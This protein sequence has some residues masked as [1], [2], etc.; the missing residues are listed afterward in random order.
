MPEDPEYEVTVRT[1]DLKSAD[2][3]MRVV[4]QATQVEAAD[5]RQVEVEEV[6]APREQRREE[7][8]RRVFGGLQ[9]P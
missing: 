3:V 4:E 6:K 7:F 9:K 1:G 2:Y 5:I 8:Y